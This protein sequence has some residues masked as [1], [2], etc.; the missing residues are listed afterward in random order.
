LTDSAKLFLYGNE[1]VALAAAHA[2]VKMGTGYP[3]T[4][5][6]EILE[7]LAGFGDP[8]IVARWAPNEKV[9]LEVGLGAAFA[10]ARTLVTMKHVGVNVAADPLFT[11]AYTGVRGGL[12]LV[13]AD[14]PAMHSSQ[15]EQDNRHY[16]E[17]A[18]L[19]MLEPAS[20]QE[21]YDFTRLAFELS[22]RY[23]TIV[24]LRPT[25]R[26]CHSKGIVTPRAPDAIERRYVFERDIPRLVM[27]PGNARKRH[28][29][30]EAKL[31]ELAACSNAS[32]LNVCVGE[33]KGASIGVVASGVA[34]QY[35]REVAPDLP[36]LKVGMCWPLPL[37]R[38][39]EF[40][41]A[42]GEVLVVEELSDFMLDHIRA[43]GIPARGKHPS[44]RLGELSPDR[45]ER[46]LAGKPAAEPKPREDLPPPR[47]PVLCPGCGHRSVFAILKK[48]KLTVT[49]D[50][51]CYTLGALPPLANLDTCICMGASIGN[52]LGIERVVEPEQAR[53]VVAVI[54]DSTFFH[55]GLTGVLDAVYNG[56]SGTLLIL[57]NR[58]TAMTGG[59]AHPGTGKRLDGADAPAIDPA[60][61]C[62]GLGVRDVKVVDPY[63]RAA[64]EQM[65][66]ESLANDAFSVIVCRHPCLLLTRGEKRDLYRVEPQVCKDCGACL[67]VGCPALCQAEGHVEIL[68]AYCAGCGLCADVCKF[69]AIVK[70]DA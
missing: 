54:G 14:D 65:L 57:D 45:V 47:P 2:G 61:V 64:L 36:V 26:T 60:D 40:T 12:V 21:A 15:N 44:F 56:S 20:S 11:A 27:V 59:Q 39:A 9:A 46:I 18:G 55:S 63:D 43:A 24:L 42:V 68:T 30:L 67:R 22:E 70:V 3:G 35:V 31:E 8:A 16:A 38:I 5:S 66:N 29:A 28:K 7:T 6:T 33:A 58:T 48:L 23:E 32:E 41:K 13:T 25:T 53:R 50:I 1:A 4:P 17:A 19:P 49:G 34:Y 62:R 51:G 69:G 10:G 37:Q 52:A